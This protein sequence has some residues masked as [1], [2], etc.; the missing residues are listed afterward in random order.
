[1]AIKTVNT[2]PVLTGITNGSA[3]A[4]TAVAAAGDSVPLSGRYTQV[5]FRTGTA[6]ATV[7]IDSV[8]PSS[9]GTDVDGKV[10]LGI[11][12]EQWILIDNSNRRFDQGVTGGTSG[13]ANLTYTT[14]PGITFAVFNIP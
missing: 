12:D 7:T 10:V 4:F 13:L 14:T 5:G 9:Y 3:P 2:L 1:M 11:S 8:V 6:G